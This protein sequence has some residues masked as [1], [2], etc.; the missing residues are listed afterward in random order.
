[1]FFTLLA[2]IED[3]VERKAIADMY[4]EHR[5][6]C[7]LTAKSVLQ[8]DILA[9]DAVQDTFIAVIKY[10]EKILSLNTEELLPYLVTVARHKAVDIL[11]KRKSIANAAELESVKEMNV[12]GE[13]PTEMQVI[14]KL[15]YENVRQAIREL[16]G[17]YRIILEMKFVRQ[18][19]L[20]EIAVELNLTKKNVE[21][22]LQRAKQSLRNRCGDRG[23]EVC[24]V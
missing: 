24:N 2:A 14:T 3:V 4:D 12:D 18:L 1:M 16:S 9:E 23:K 10:K 15:D 20:D 6:V 17:N 21:T 19:T 13:N 7:F 5:N 22:R 11:R 8:D